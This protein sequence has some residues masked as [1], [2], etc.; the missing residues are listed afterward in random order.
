LAAVGGILAGVLLG[1]RRL[2]HATCLRDFTPTVVQ[3]IKLPESTSF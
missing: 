1:R 3:R 2:R